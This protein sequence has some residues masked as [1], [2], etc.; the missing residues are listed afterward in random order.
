MS[1][2]A[3]EQIRAQAQTRLEKNMH[4]KSMIIDRLGLDV[5]PAVVSDNQPLF[6]RGLEMDS[7][8]TL[9]IVVMINSEYAVLI[10]DDDFEAF[11]SINALVDFV[12]AREARP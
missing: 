10:S 7:L 11:G 5:E 2:A 12:A 9:E 4:V 8:D 3:F 1:V 6:G